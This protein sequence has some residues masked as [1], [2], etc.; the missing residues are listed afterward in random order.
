[1]ML[2]S[3]TNL[4]YMFVKIKE[5]LF[6]IHLIILGEQSAQSVSKCLDRSLGE[7]WN[8]KGEVVRVS[9]KSPFYQRVVLSTY[10]LH[11][12]RISRFREFT[13]KRG[14]MSIL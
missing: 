1:M 9:E 10:F 13:L 11:K 14:G 3:K 12:P 5:Q 6:S 2:V 8:K 4:I 7:C